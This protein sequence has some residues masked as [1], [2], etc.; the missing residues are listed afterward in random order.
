MQAIQKEQQKAKISPLKAG[1]PVAA[2]ARE[3][4]FISV[5]YGCPMAWFFLFY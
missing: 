5:T 1:K 4:E 2:A 3:G